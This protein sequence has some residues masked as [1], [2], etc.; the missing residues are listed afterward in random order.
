MGAGHV[1]HLTF[2][3]A[4]RKLR[5]KAAH[6]YGVNPLEIEQLGKD[7]AVVALV[8]NFASI[9]WTRMKELHEYLG[10]RPTN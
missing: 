1:Y 10:S 3:N 6:S 7:P 2:L 4:L 5:N 9:I 8:S